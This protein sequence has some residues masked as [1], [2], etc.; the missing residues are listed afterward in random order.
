VTGFV[1]EPPD[2]PDDVEPSYEDCPHCGTPQTVDDMPN[3][4][5]T[6]VKRPR[7]T[8]PKPR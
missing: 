2:P 1:R 7:P 3:H 5:Q 6:C 4:V 8:Q